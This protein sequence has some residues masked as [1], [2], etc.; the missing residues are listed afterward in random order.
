[1][2]SVKKVGENEDNN[3]KPILDNIFGGEVERKREQA[4]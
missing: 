4:L 3:N 1:M 2:F